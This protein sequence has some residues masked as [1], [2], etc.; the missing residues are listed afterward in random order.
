MNIKIEIK[1]NMRIIKLENGKEVKISEESYKALV[2]A[3]K[4]PEHSLGLDIKKTRRFLYD[5]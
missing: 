5:R 4:E 2:E 3:A 1:I